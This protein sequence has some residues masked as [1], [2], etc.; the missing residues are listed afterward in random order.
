MPTSNGLLFQ[1]SSFKRCAILKVYT[2]ENFVEE[3]SF[4]QRSVVKN[5]KKEAYLLPLSSACVS[6][7]ILLLPGRALFSVPIR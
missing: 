6:M 2:E 1:V 4:S 7:A 5:R 3:I